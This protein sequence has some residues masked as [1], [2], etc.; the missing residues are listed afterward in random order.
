MM[1]N[2][3]LLFFAIIFTA[4][5]SSL[6]AQSDKPLE[7]KGKVVSEQ[8]SPVP[9][10][11]VIVH[12][13]PDSAFYSGVVTADD[14][15]FTVETPAGDYFL[16]VSCIGFKTENYSPSQV[17]ANG[18]RIK[19]QE[20]TQLLQ[21]VQVVGYRKLFRPTKE[22]LSVN[23]E[24]TPLSR[25]GTLDQLLS[26]LPLIAG[27]NGDFTVLGHGKP[28]FY[29]NN[30][31]IRDLSEL[32]T[33]HS[34]DVES[35]DIVTNPGTRYGSEITSVIR[36]KTK[37]KQGQGLSGSA[38]ASVTKDEKWST[39]ENLHLMYSF[40]NGMQLFS[41]VNFSST[42]FKQK[43]EYHE[44][45]GQEAITRTDTYGTAENSA[46]RYTWQS[47]F[48]YDYGSS[49][50]LGVRY[51]WKRTPKVDFTLASR[52]NTETNTGNPETFSG[53]TAIHS[54]DSRHSL[55]AYLIQKVGKSNLSFDA[56]YLHGDEAKVNTTSEISLSADDKQNIL[57]HFNSSYDLYAA[58]LEVST[59]V[60]KGELLYG[61]EFS[62]T[63]R[64]QLFDNKTS[65]ETSFLKTT[66]DNTQQNLYALFAEYDYSLKRTNFYA[67]VRYE[68]ND[69]TYKQNDSIISE[70]SKKYNTW[71]P[72]AGIK[73]NIK[74]VTLNL[75]YKTYIFRP[76]YSLL[77]SN[78]T[79]VSHTLW[80]TG[81]PYLKPSTRYN[82]G[83]DLSW[84]DFQLMG[85][86][87]HRKQDISPV[88]EEFNDGKSIVSKDINLPEY[89]I[90]SL[91]A[92]YSHTTKIWQPSVQAYIQFQDLKYGNPRRSYNK[93]LCQIMFRNRFTLPSDYYLY[94]NA[95]YLS[96]GNDRALYSFG[97]FYMSGTV[98]KKFKS[99]LSV[100][101][102]ASD[103]LNTLKQKNGVFTNTVSYDYVT[104]GASHA[105]SLTLSYDLNMTKSKYKGTGAGESEK[106]R[107]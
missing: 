23:I 1:R 66:K 18:F 92:V 24:A 95:F 13:L 32:T 7:I 96:K 22:G 40:S 74:D 28:E 50:S 38:L 11:N 36:I 104:T 47:G 91:T 61:G 19:L 12:T 26:Q 106:D 79:Y 68:R 52:I 63:G 10:A 3:C 107:L 34:S 101:L 53:T 103:F 16:A 56:D 100:S 30:R 2:N 35:V 15:S 80:E 81:N 45:F 93:P 42:A 76:G 4:A 64:E 83:F 94:L 85:D 73:F 69:F 25:I 46:N 43:R 6:C 90:Y 44:A 99:G 71:L 72:Y 87:T 86:I 58:K 88:Y 9:Y 70:Q 21:E 57:T 49:N 54:D 89:N 65:T 62:H 98:Q 84:K 60:A 5:Y 77:T 37:K 8:N 67:G 97:M 29:L 33:I 51:E 39:N 59:P 102:R 14:G 75:R 55:N 41:N 20:D 78:Y 27:E 17:Q 82:G 48:N 31:K 105:I